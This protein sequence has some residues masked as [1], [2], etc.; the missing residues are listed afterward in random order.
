M[1]CHSQQHRVKVGVFDSLEHGFTSKLNFFIPLDKRVLLI[2][3]KLAI[4]T[5]NASKCMYM[6]K[7]THYNNYEENQTKCRM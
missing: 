5:R 7:T 2:S 1:S 6:Y 3:P 4:L